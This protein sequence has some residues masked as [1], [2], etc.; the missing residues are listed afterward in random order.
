MKNFLITYIEDNEELGVYDKEIIVEETN[1]ITCFKK[2]IMKYPTLYGI[3]MISD[4]IDPQWKDYY[5]HESQ[6]QLR[7]SQLELQ[8]K[9]STR[10]DPMEPRLH[11]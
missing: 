11:V 9:I 6:D 5:S 2:Y 3:K 7:K 4:T 1:M 8:E 10:I